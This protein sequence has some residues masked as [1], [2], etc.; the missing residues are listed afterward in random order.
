MPLLTLEVS[1]SILCV[2]SADSPSAHRDYFGEVEE[3]ELVPG[4]R[5]KAVTLENKQQYV[6]AY[7]DYYLNHSIKAQYEAFAHVSN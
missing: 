4:G 7:V 6:A 3:V 1:S 5:D 2:W